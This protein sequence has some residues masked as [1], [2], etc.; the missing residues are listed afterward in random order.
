[1]DEVVVDEKSA[2]LDE[3]WHDWVLHANIEPVVGS[4]V[5]SDD[6]CLS[7]ESSTQSLDAALALGAV[8]W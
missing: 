6:T 2:V 1:M 4:D 5:L 3:P 8:G 7:K